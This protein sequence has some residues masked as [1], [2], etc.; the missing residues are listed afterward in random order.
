[1]QNH[2]LY[3]I[4]MFFLMIFFIV[5]FIQTWNGQFKRL[6]TRAGEKWTVNVRAT[7]SVCHHYK[8]TGFYLVLSNYGNNTKIP[9]MT[10]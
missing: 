4:K 1:M 9:T 5:C 10:I 6:F 7:C 3:K 8:I 2:L